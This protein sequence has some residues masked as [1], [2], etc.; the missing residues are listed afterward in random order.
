[1]LMLPLVESF[2]LSKLRAKYDSLNLFPVTIH[3]FYLLS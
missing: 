3:W 1:M 2:N